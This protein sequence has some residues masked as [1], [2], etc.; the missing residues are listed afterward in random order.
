MWRTNGVG[1][2]TVAGVM[3]AAAAANGQKLE[4]RME[5]ATA[6][7]CMFTSQAVGNWTGGTPKVDVRTPKLT[8][9]FTEVSTDEGSAKA[10]GEFGSSDILVRYSSGNLHFLQSFRTG[11]L[12]ITSLF[13]RE[14]T[15]GS[16]KLVAAHTRHEFTAVAL[17]GFTSRPEQYY[18]ECELK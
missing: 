5:R 12:Y 10:V 15:P 4:E 7:T 18:G 3:F 9:Q 6:V 13:N 16:G 17:P 2:L 14:V 11:P 1:T 8:V